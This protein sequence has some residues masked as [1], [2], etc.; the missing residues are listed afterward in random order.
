MLNNYFLALEVKAKI[1]KSSQVARAR[2][3]CL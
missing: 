3:S 2:L 1:E